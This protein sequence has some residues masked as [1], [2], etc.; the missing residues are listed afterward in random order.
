VP[1]HLLAVGDVIPH[2]SLVAAAGRLGWPSLFADVAPLISAADLAIFN[3]ETPCAPS[4]PNPTGPIVFDAPPA[5]LQA[6]HT[7]G[8]DAASEANN[9][10]WDQGRVGLVETLAQLDAAGLAGAGTG[11][12][13]AA[14]EA[15]RMSTVG[16]VRVGW[17]SATRV[18]NYPYLDG[19]PGWPCV[20]E[21]SVDRVQAMAQRAR[22]AGAEI[23]V[24]SAHWG[25]EYSPV[26]APV[27]EAM[28]SAFVS[29]GVDVV[30]G[31]HP[32]VLQPIAWV[33]SGDRRGL[34]A[35]SLGNFAT[36]QSLPTRAGDAL[37]SRRD[38]AILDIAIERIDG[39]AAVTGAVAIPTTVDGRVGCAGPVV[40]P[41]VE[42]LDRPPG[43]ACEAE[44][45]ARYAAARAAL[46]A[47][48]VADPRPTP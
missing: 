47:S 3:L 36:G 46:G 4:G 19:R 2:D 37:A 23:V 25:E 14:A 34:V 7:V 11:P 30:L 43:P 33:E 26:P 38:G 41:R 44:Y 45:A 48:W 21:L 6:L 16:D 12:D 5:M 28:A 35:Y 29:D 1:L 13:C 40:H 27:D 9:H 31:H 39:K 15:P 22:A 32:H 17:I 24:L 42:R 20:A 18:H 8:F 10:A